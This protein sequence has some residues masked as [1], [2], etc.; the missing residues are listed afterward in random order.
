[1]NLRLWICAATLACGVVSSCSWQGQTAFDTVAEAYRT[2]GDTLKAQAAEYLAR[3]ARYHYGVRRDIPS[4][5]D[6]TGHLQAGDAAFKRHLDSCGC[7]EVRTGAPVLDTDT[8]TPEFLRE[9]IDLAF[10]SWQRPWARDVSFTDFC[11]YILPYRNGNEQLSRWRR[12]F[13]ERYES[14]VEDSV[15]DPHNIRQV[16]SYLMR[17]LRREI[18]YGPRTG[19]LCQELL[20]PE[21]IERM[22]W[23]GCRNCA[24]YATLALRACGVPCATIDIFWRFT[25]V[26]HS[27]V[28]FPSVGGNRRAFR[29]TIGDT[30]QYMGEPKDSMATW[31]TWSYA[32][33]PDPTLCDLLAT[34]REECAR[35]KMLRGF[36]LPLT[37]QDVTAQFATTWP[38]T[39]PVPDSLRGEKYLFLC[40]F[41]EW[42]WRPVREG[43]VRGDS[44]YFRDATIRQWYRLGYVDADSIRTFGTPFTLLGDSALTPQERI[45]PYDLTGD[46]V[47]F[48]RVYNCSPEERRLTRD[49]TTYYWGRRDRWEAYRG[50]AVLWG[51]NPETGEYRVFEEPM[52]GEFTPV[53]H[54]MELRL[55]CWTVFTDNETARP[56]GFIA[57]DPETDE[58][59]FM[60]F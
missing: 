1:M 60:E 30:L 56:L 14:T 40:R 36:V 48:K 38:L 10:D 8:L 25:E 52:R 9:N 27:S 57:K 44:A 42:K 43:R 13:K 12:R 35:S 53:F 18:A 49:I 24:H 4:C 37:R 29:L 3:S 16:A 51:L 21:G 47:L 7:T 33:E 19:S 6:T 32:Y 59:Y 54:L 46:T 5:V 50:K 17:C 41:Y 2:Q 58:G 22:H 55:P 34:Y 45:R 23:A 39:L 20:T 15:A 26:V 28:L 11:R 31:R